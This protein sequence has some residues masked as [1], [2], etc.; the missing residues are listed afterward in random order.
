MQMKH[1]LTGAFAAVDVQPV[2]G[3][4]DALIARDLGRC[5][6]KALRAPHGVLS[7]VVDRRD[8]L[9]GNDQHMDGGLGVKVPKGEHLI[10]FVDE[11]RRNLPADD[12]AKDAVRGH[13]PDL[14]GSDRCVSNCVHA[15]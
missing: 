15:R 9:P 3:V 1:R 14:L 11:F 4:R 7:Q 10:V 13:F 2:S 5:E 8:M 12:A 6:E